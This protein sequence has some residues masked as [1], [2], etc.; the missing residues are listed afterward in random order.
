MM[1]THG[2]HD[3]NPRPAVMLQGRERAETAHH[4]ESAI[5]R[6]KEKMYFLSVDVFCTVAREHQVPAPPRARDSGGM[7]CRCLRPSRRFCGIAPVS[8]QGQRTVDEALVVSRVGGGSCG[9]PGCQ[10]R[11]LVALPIARPISSQGHR[12][13]DECLV[14]SWVGE[15]LTVASRR[16][17]GMPVCGYGASAATSTERQ[18]HPQP[19]KKARHTRNQDHQRPLSQE[20]AEAARAGT[21][22]AFLAASAARESVRAAAADEGP[23][24]GPDAKNHLAAQKRAKHR[25][26][27]HRLR[28]KPVDDLISTDSELVFDEW[29]VEDADAE[30]FDDLVSTDSELLPGPTSRGHRGSSQW[31]SCAYGHRDLGNGRRYQKGQG[32]VSNM[33]LTGMRSNCSGEPGSHLIEQGVVEER[34]RVGQRRAV[35]SGEYPPAMCSQLAG[36]I[37]C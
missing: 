23:A 8:S 29:Q 17:C 33:E 19:R 4:T 6:G 3:D 9:W 14:V 18:A 35:I 24:L 26:I 25:R 34:D 12:V 15:V 7:E 30:P 16:A 36:I 13:M 5:R 37:L 10:S 11:S 1:A 28:P 20:L 2:Y 32:F 22:P 31:P 21:L 27:R